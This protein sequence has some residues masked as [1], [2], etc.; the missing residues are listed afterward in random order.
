MKYVSTWNDVQH[1][2][3][4]RNRA[5]LHTHTL[6]VKSLGTFSTFACYSLHIYSK[7]TQCSLLNLQCVQENI[8]FESYQSPNIIII[9]MWSNYN[10]N[11]K[12]YSVLKQLTSAFKVGEHLTLHQNTTRQ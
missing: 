5:H 11:V 6:P 3:A 12:C 7:Y 9:G 10:W 4:N 2:A 8:I 1:R